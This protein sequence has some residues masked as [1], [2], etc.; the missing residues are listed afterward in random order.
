M[1]DLPPELAGI[2]DL[3]RV[4]HERTYFHRGSFSFLLEN[5]HDDRFSVWVYRLVDWHEI[6]HLELSSGTGDGALYVPRTHKS[7][8]HPEAAGEPQP[9]R[10]AIAWLVDTVEAN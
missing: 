9:W 3:P 1:T 5:D 4:R 2:D 10:D 7:H 6:G 8:G